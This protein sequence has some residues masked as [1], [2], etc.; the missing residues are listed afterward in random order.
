[1]AITYSFPKVAVTLS[2]PD[3]RI[4][5]LPEY[6]SGIARNGVLTLRPVRSQEILATLDDVTAVRIIGR[7]RWEIDTATGTVL[8]LVKP[9]GCGCGSNR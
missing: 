5:A 2:T 3:A 7:R 6:V 1:M 8:T 9:A 4:P